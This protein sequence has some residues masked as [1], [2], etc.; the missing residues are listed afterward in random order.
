MTKLGV[1]RNLVPKST[2]VQI[3]TTNQT[4]SLLCRLQILAPLPK[5]QITILYSVSTHSSHIL[6]ESQGLTRSVSAAA[7]QQSA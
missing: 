1:K 2:N 7:D 5:S 6:K 4:Q 3:D